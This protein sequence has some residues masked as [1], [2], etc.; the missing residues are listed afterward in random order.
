MYED[1]NSIRYN[2]I[3]WR[4]IEGRNNLYIYDSIEVLL[5]NIYDYMEQYINGIIQYEYNNGEV[6]YVNVILLVFN[7]VVL[8][9][10]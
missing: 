7:M 9:N 3:M 5:D 4:I 2:G 10:K 6:K 1:D 8:D